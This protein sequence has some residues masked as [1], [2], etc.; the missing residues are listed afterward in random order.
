MFESR[1]ENIK[2]LFKMI[3]HKSREIIKNDPYYEHQQIAQWAKTKGLIRMKT[4]E[5]ID[6]ELKKK[7]W[8]KINKVI[9]KNEAQQDADTTL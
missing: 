3:D 4:Q 1:N 7:P 6:K 5:E 2:G 8:L 9:R